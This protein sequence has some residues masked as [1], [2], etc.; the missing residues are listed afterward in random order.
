MAPFSAKKTAKLF[1]QFFPVPPDNALFL[2]TQFM[3]TLQYLIQS[4]V[5]SVIVAGKQTATATRLCKVQMSLVWGSGG[6]ASRIPNLGTR[7]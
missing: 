2:R 7:R 3:N 5:S 4:H 1:S 6:V